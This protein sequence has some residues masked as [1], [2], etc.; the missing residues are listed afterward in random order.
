MGLKNFFRSLSLGVDR[1]FVA[2]G[3]AVNGFIVCALGLAP[4]VR[5][6]GQPTL[7][8]TNANM[9]A[10][11]KKDTLAI[12]DGKQFK[13]FILCGWDGKNQNEI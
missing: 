11:N 2:N 8:P 9:E 13:L 6:S 12:F 5:A 10:L 1:L 4:S 3:L 7:E